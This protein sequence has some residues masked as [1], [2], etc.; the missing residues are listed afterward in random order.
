MRFHNFWILPILFCLV[1][2]SSSK[3]KSTSQTKI[4][5]SHT[6]GYIRLEGSMLY[7]SC[8][9]RAGIFKQT[10]LDLN[11]C[12]ANNDGILMLGPGNFLLTCS[13]C[14]LSYYNVLE[15]QCMRRDGNSFVNTSFNLDMVVDHTDGN[16][17]CDPFRSY[18]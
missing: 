12:L 13:D 14:R 15:C 3:I 11:S 17:V 7:A 9:T 18:F 5:F 4:N 2:I 6:C 1:V 16:L 10:V 8:R